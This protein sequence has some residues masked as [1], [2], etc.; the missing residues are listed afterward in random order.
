MTGGSSM[1]AITR[2]FPPQRRQASMSMANT[3][4][5]RCA[6]VIAHCRSLADGFTALSGLVVSTGPDPWHDSEGEVLRPP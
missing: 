3:R 4:F 5:R 6:Q 2:S 1:L